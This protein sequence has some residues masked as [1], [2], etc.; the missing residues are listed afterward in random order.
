MKKAGWK[1][2][3]SYCKFRGPYQRICTRSVCN[4]SQL[5][6]GRWFWKKIPKTKLGGGSKYFFL[7]SPLLGEMIRF[8][9]IFQMGWNHQLENKCHI[10]SVCCSCWLLVIFE[11]RTCCAT[12]WCIFPQ[13]LLVRLPVRAVSTELPS[14]WP[15]CLLVEIFPKTWW[16]TW[17]K[18]WLFRVYRLYRGLHYLVFVGIV[19]TPLEGSLLNNQDSMESKRVFSWLMWTSF[20]VITLL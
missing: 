16:V 12:F 19:I 10:S 5:K 11:T 6:K 17:K 4:G 7:C 13:V 18:T 15:Q 2:L 20:V 9:Y 1:F 8:D 14:L 3:F